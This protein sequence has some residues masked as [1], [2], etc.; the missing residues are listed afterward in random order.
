MQLTKNDPKLDEKLGKQL[1][2]IKNCKLELVSNEKL[3]G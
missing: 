2:I 1:I 3:S